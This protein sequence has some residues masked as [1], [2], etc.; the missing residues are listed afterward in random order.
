MNKLPTLIGLTGKAGAGKT[1]VGD[2]LHQEKGYMQCAF[3]DELKSE[4]YDAIRG[5]GRPV[6]DKAK[7]LLVLLDPRERNPW[8][9]PTSPEMR[10]LLQWWGTEYRRAED[11]YYWL[12]RLK[13]SSSFAVIEDIRFPNEVDLLWALGGDL[14]EINGRASDGVPAHVSEAGTTRTPDVVITNDGSLEELY[15]KVDF[16]LE[17]HLGEAATTK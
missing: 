10:A 13:I 4:V 8:V 17:A 12:R 11:P 16:Y 3:A 14:W 2:Y 6:P 15:K 1:T 7:E 9:K 5:W